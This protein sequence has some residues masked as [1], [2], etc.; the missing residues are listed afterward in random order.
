MVVQRPGTAC[1]EAL[2]H[3]HQAGA[4]TVAVE[5]CICPELRVERFLQW[6]G[7]ELWRQQPEPPELGL[8]NIRPDPGVELLELLHRHSTGQTGR[9]DRPGR[10]PA[11]EIEVVA[12]QEVRVVESPP[13]L[14]FHNFKVFEGKNAANPTAIKGQYPLWSIRRVQMLL[15]GLRHPTLPGG[16]CYRRCRA[17][18]HDNHLA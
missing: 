8:E 9:N 11:D 15:L 3:D 14:A 17:A 13:E 16:K 5:R 2:R 4:D 7:F 1:V 6:S 10:C 12:E 18:L